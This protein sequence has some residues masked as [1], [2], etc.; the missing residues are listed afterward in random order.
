MAVLVALDAA[1]TPGDYDRCKRM[2]EGVDRLEQLAMVD[3]FIAARR[4]V[5][6]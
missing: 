2:A 3:S 1:R 5:F 4:R 6:P